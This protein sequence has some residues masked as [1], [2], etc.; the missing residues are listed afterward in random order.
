MKF[1]RGWRGVVEAEID[2]VEIP[3]ISNSDL[4][5]DN[6]ATDRYRDWADVE[7]LEQL[8]SKIED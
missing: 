1:E 7:E 5:E 2:G 6:K 4:I 8:S 3:F